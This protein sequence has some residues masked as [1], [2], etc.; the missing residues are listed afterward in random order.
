MYE[1]NSAPSCSLSTLSSSVKGWCSSKPLT[2]HLPISFR[3]LAS[4]TMRNTFLFFLLFIYLF[5]LYLKSK[6]T[7][8]LLHLLVHTPNSPKIQLGW[9]EARSPG[10][11]PAFSHGCQKLNRITCHL[12]RPALAGSWIR[13]K[14]WRGRVGSLL[15]MAYTFK[16]MF[17]MPLIYV[18]NFVLQHPT[19]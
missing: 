7:E 8:R 2:R 10:L 18:F 9:V 15:L 12:P 6:E 19:G 1:E 3:F 13:L 17:K 11:S 14:S 5:S 16:I 4:R